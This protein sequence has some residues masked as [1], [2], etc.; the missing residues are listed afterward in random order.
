MMRYLKKKEYVAQSF[1]CFLA[2]LTLWAT[3]MPKHCPEG[4]EGEEGKKEEKKKEKEKKGTE[5]FQS[6]SMS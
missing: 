1:C 2:F 3:S 5:I 6:T 4:G